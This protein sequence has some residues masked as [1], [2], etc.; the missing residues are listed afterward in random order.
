MALGA[1]ARRI[2]QLVLGQG[3]LQLGIGVL[4]GVG[5]AAMLSRAL[6]AMLFGVNP[7]DPVVFALVVATLGVS[8][9]A[10]CLIPAARA[11]RLDPVDALRYE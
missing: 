10:A 2:V 8:G 1:Q 11:I 3:G 7:W 9:F 4:L 6:Q 5:F